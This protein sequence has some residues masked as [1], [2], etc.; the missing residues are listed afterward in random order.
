MADIQAR[1]YWVATL[2]ILTA[3][4]NTIVIVLALYEDSN[5]FNVDISYEQTWLAILGYFFREP[6]AL[7]LVLPRIMRVN[8]KGNKLKHMFVN[9]DLD[10]YA[11][12]GDDDDG[13]V[14]KRT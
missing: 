4:I 1:N 12:R 5:S 6:L 13:A 9:R 10:G 8:E 11:V 2:V 3:T 7:I 14:K